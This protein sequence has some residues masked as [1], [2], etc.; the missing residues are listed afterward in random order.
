MSTPNGP[1][2]DLNVVGQGGVHG[3]YIVHKFGRNPDVDAAED[4]WGGGGDY[5]GFPSGAAET[6]ETFSSSAADASAGTGARTWRWYYLDE[7]LN[8]FDANGEWLYFDVTLNGVTGVLSTV[9]GKRIWRGRCRT[10][11]SGQTN[12][13]TITVRWSTTTTAVFAIAPAGAGATYLSSFTIPAGYTGY[14][15]QFAVSLSDVGNASNRAVVAAKMITED[16]VLSYQFAFAA[17]TES[18]FSYQPSGG[19]QIPEK[20]DIC[21]RV[22]SVKSTNADV[23]IKYDVLLVP[24]QQ[25]LQP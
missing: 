1:Y 15:T 11:G 4:I 24:L 16:G 22:L 20:T 12:A 19:I 3:R 7:D 10:A 13:G 9:T 18:E 6:F 2:Y 14:V 5:T 25:T 8:A 23:L 17:S 21:G